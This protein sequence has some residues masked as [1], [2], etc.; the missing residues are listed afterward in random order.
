VANARIRR[1]GQTALHLAA[2]TNNAEAIRLLTQAGADV[3]AVDETGCAPLDVALKTGS[4]ND[5]ALALAE[6]GAQIT[7]ERLEAMQ[8]GA[9]GPESTLRFFPTVDEIAFQRPEVETPPGSVLPDPTTTSPPELKCPHCGAVLYS[10]KTRVCEKCG[11]SIPTT[12]RVDD[13]QS[14]K[15]ERERAESIADQV[16]GLPWRQDFEPRPV[17]RFLRTAFAVNLLLASAVL[18]LYVF[19]CLLADFPISEYFLQG[20]R[21]RAGRGGGPKLPAWSFTVILQA[22]I[23][24]SFLAGRFIEHKKEAAARVFGGMFGFF[25]VIGLL[26][27]HPEAPAVAVSSFDYAVALYLW[28]SN[29]A[30]AI[31][32][33]NED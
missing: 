8:S 9:Y 3:E 13:D 4:P 30:F 32:G 18:A 2:A 24:T 19:Y 10:R 20:G 5:A 28:S 12:L 27:G 16:G 17:V 25:F 14:R 21:W 33:S 6:A 26:F 7:P 1:G 23:V 22:I 11:V 29:L 15:A 31:L